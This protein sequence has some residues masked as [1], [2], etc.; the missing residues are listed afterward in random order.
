MVVIETPGGFMTVRDPLP[1]DIVVRPTPVSGGGGGIDMTTREMPTP[2]A[3]E[4]K[5]TAQEREAQ[6]TAFRSGGQQAFETER[7]KAEQRIFGE[8]AKE[9]LTPGEEASILARQ[10]LKTTAETRGRS[11]TRLE[12]QRFIKERG[13]DIS[14]LRTGEAKRKAIFTEFGVDI[15]EDLS[16]REPVSQDMLIDTPD[17]DARGFFVLEAPKEPE[18]FFERRREARR[19]ERGRL[20]VSP[21]RLA[22]IEAESSLLGTAEFFVETPGKIIGFGKELFTK[23]REK[24]VDIVSG[25]KETIAVLPTTIERGGRDIGRILQQQPTRAVGFIAT[26]VATL[27]AIAKAPKFI[28]K[29]TDIVRTAR[30]K[31]LQATDIIAPEIKLGQTFPKIKRGETAGE[32]LEEFKPV[33]PGETKPAG[34]TATPIPF[35]KETIAMRGTSELPGVFQAP[36]VSPRFLR[37]SGEEEK[38]FLSLKLFDTPRPSIVRITPE[39]FELVP[40]VSPKQKVLGSLPKAREFFEEAPKGKSFIPFIKTE[41]EAVIPF[42]TPLRLQQKRFFIKF[43]GR[44][45]PIF[46]FKADPSPLGKGLKQPKLPTAREISESLSSRRIGRRGAVTPS[47]LS[48]I[49]RLSSRRGFLPSR[50]SLVSGLSSFGKGTPVSRGFGDVSRI[51]GDFFS[52]F[53]IPKSTRRGG[54]SKGVSS[55]IG[56]TATIPKFPKG[57]LPAPLKLDFEIKKKAKRPKGKR[58]LKRTPSLGA[59]IK[60]EFDVKQPKFETRLEET[61]IFERAIV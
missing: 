30:L 22:F 57:I 60:F 50:A 14:T 29:G 10:E 12:T 5:G 20:D 43:E 17:V 3:G 8:K 58:V 41:K 7:A 36:R 32:L 11:F 26:E 1:T 18:G 33:L 19:F 13:G 27:G 40:G 42:E 48:S 35:K 2:A 15:T 31:E 24:I 25:T 54:V 39:S 9:V 16:Q 4:L 34:F 56:G 45:V 55:I 49:P 53:S 51:R 6:I 38:K 37:I 28:L 59:V 61:G 44:R 47:E 23:P 52:G 46:E 21:T